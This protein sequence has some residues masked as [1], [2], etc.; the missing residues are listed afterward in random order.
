[1]SRI[2]APHVEGR[3]GA[4][5]SDTLLCAAVYLGMFENRQ[6]NASKLAD[7]VGVPSFSRPQRD[8][9]LI[10]K[11]VTVKISEI[12]SAAWAGPRATLLTR[13]K[14]PDSNCRRPSNDFAVVQLG[15][16]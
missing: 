9:V 15:D 8:R 4:D 2:H 5:A 3:F 7:Y 10:R 6:M 11:Y 14:V 16:W 12:R 1:M 13:Q